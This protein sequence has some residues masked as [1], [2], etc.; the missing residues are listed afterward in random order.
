MSIH[1]HSLVED[2]PKPAA[3]SSRVVAVFSSDEGSREGTFAV[4]VATSMFGMLLGSTIAKLSQVLSDDRTHPAAACGAMV[5]VASILLALVAGFRFK[6]SLRAGRLGH[7]G[8]ALLTLAVVSLGWAS[9]AMI[10]F[11]DWRL[12]AGMRL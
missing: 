11:A 1:N 4:W 12:P 6:A 2:H 8:Q 3:T 9:L 7:S 10:A 5:V